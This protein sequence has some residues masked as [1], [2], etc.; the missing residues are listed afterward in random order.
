MYMRSEVIVNL[1]FRQLL[2]VLI[3]SSRVRCGRGQLL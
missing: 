3:F 2:L 1:E